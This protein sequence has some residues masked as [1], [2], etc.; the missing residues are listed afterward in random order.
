MAG[1]SGKLLLNLISTLCNVKFKNVHFV[2]QCKI[3]FTSILRPKT[4]STE[5]GTLVC[6]HTYM[7]QGEE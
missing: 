4:I 2:L 1:D 5:T 7:Y 3:N 6:A